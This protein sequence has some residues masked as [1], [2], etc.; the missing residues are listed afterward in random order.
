M[1]SDGFIFGP[2]FAFLSFVT[3]S[4]EIRASSLGLYSH[5]RWHR[6]GGVF[7]ACSFRMGAWH[8]AFAP[9][10]AVILVWRKSLGEVKGLK[11]V[12][13]ARRTGFS[14]P[15]LPHLIL[16]SGENGYW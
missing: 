8:F 13:S 9:G 4:Y 7:I 5:V 16:T 11:C 1:H 2:F 6:M 15:L 3:A 10:W 14:F 12:M